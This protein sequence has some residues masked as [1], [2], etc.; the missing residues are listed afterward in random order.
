[1]NSAIKGEMKPGKRAAEFIRPR[2]FPDGC[3]K[4]SSQALMVWSPLKRLPSSRS[5]SAVRRDDEFDALTSIEEQRSTESGAVE[6]IFP[7]AC[8]EMSEMD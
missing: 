1:M 5:Q 7:E 8:I 2:R 6:D 4:Y 3:P